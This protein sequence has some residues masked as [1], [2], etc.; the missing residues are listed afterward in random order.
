MFRDFRQASLLYSLR[1]LPPPNCFVRNQQRSGIMRRF[2][3]SV[4][5]LADFIF[6]GRC[7]RIVLS[8]N[9]TAREYETLSMSRQLSEPS[10]FVN[11]CLGP[12]RKLPAFPPRLS[13]SDSFFRTVLRREANY[14][15]DP[16]SLASVSR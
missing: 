3:I 4:K 15:K 16:G 10:Q 13:E 8:V 1:I 12:A 7:C 5:R 6:T 2:V 11:I 14:I 9:R